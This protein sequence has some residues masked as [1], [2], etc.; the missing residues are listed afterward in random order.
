MLEIDNFTF[1]DSRS[2][3]NSDTSLP[4]TIER[5]WA[6]STPQPFSDGN[7]RLQD[8]TFA[9]TQAIETGESP[10]DI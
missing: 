3:E 9:L 8:S 7:G 10:E 5:R 2:E 1:E 6:R 4:P